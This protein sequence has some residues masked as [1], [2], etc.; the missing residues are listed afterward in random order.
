MRG[1]YI[2][3]RQNRGVRQHAFNLS[4]LTCGPRPSSLDII[5]RGGFYGSTGQKP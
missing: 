3:I 2:R 1:G 4:T 5:A